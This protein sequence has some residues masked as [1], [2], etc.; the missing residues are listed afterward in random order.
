[1]FSVL[2]LGSVCTIMRLHLINTIFLKQDFFSLFVRLL[3]RN[4]S[5]YIVPVY[6]TYGLSLHFFIMKI[7]SS[8]TYIYLGIDLF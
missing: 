4:S 3:P 6:V 7:P 1:M 5:I 2:Q 8:Y